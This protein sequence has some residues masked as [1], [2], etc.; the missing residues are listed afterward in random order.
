MSL[1]EIQADFRQ[2]LEHEDD[3]AGGRLG[4]ADQRGLPVYLN[5]YRGQL[6]ACLEDSF[7]QTMA[8]IGETGFRGAAAQHIER[9]P[10]T[11]WTL[12]DYAR[13]FPTSLASGFP[14]DPEVGELAALELALADAFIATDWLA[15]EVAALAD[16]DWDATIL[17]LVPACA[18]LRC[19][20]NAPEIW[21]A[22]AGQAEVPAAET[23][24]RDRTVLVWR[25]DRVCRFRILDDDEAHLLGAVFDGGA[26]FEAICETLVVQRGGEAG[27]AQAGALL[28]QWMQDGLLCQP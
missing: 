7:P 2:W 3:A 24:P 15:L 10:P 12:D 22:L 27:V 6:M 21:T 16:M 11:S 9:C 18:L 25:H 8:W 20:S 26:R 19:R 13:G 4:L 14:D 17:S 23:G 5:N 28:V 1:A